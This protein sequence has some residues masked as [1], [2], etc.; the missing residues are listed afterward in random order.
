MTSST[1]ERISL[2]SPAALCCAIPSLLGFEP[3]DSVVLLWFEGRSLILTQRVDIPPVDVDAA[4]WAAAV[5]SHPAAG[6]TDRVIAFVFPAPGT[7]LNLQH[8]RTLVD[9]LAGQR[10]A[11]ALEGV[12]VRDGALVNLRC[13][14]SHCCP[15]EG[16]PIEPSLRDAV[17]AEFAGQ[18]VS[19]L[20]SR[21]HLVDSLGPDADLIEQV[22]ASGRLAGE[23]GVG[24]AGERREEWRDAAIAS[25]LAWLR[26]RTAASDP[27]RLAHLLLS[28]RDTRVRDTVLWELA[29]LR[30]RLVVRA[31]DQFARLLRAAPEG[32]VAPVATCACVAF[33]LIGD[34]ARAGI[35]IDRA[36][37]DAP[38][39][40]LAQ[41]FDLALRCG[42]PPHEWRDAMRMLT[43]ADCRGAEAL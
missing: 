26:D 5:G 6:M 30:T 23:R 1:A 3:T 28:L 38:E 10:W 25:V 19:P 20:R 43:R 41:V 18:G 42:K 37:Q 40:T 21:Q 22:V 29:H 4:R 11:S 31:A 7:R 16:E 34:G 14:D 13:D 35:A 32:D 12:G 27:E 39:Y 36:R 24:L 9:A 15:P 8:A 2:N 33:W 17:R